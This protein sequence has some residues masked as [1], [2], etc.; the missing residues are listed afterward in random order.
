MGT[1]GRRGSAGVVARVTSCKKWSANPSSRLRT[2]PYRRRPPT[3]LRN[4]SRALAQYALQA[5]RPL[6]ARHPQEP[7]QRV[8]PLQSRSAGR[9]A[10]PQPP[11]RAGATPRHHLRDVSVSSA[12]LLCGHVRSGRAG[13]EHRR[14]HLFAKVHAGGLHALMRRALLLERLQ[15]ALRRTARKDQQGRRSRPSEELV[16]ERCGRGPVRGHFRPAA[17]D[18]E[19]KPAEPTRAKQ[20]PRPP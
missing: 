16:A 9:P 6:P 13:T 18:A 7:L 17:Q 15:K 3:R 20:P 4:P 2:Q 10:A 11:A 1:Q 12:G 19:E 8:T 5:R 14:A